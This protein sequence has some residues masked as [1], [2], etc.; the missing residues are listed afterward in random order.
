VKSGGPI[1][2]FFMN[3][4]TDFSR[5]ITAL[6]TALGSGS[7]AVIRISGSESWSIVSKVFKGSD[8]SGVAAN[9]VHFGRIIDERREIDQVLI[10]VFK[11]PHSYTGEDCIEISCHA[12]PFLVGEITN[13]LIKNG[14]D[15]AR[16][17]EFTLRSFLNGKIDLSQAEA[18]SSIVQA[19]SRM[20]V[21]NSLQ[22][23]EGA[24]TKKVHSI[25]E[26]ILALT[27]TL[28][29]DLDFSEEN[30]TI[31]EP[32][33]T[34]KELALIDNELLHLA[35][36]FN[37]ARIFESGI[38][39]AII[40]EPNVGKSTLL[41]AMLGENRAITSDIPGTTRDLIKEN[42]LIDHIFIT[43]T[44]TAG[45]RDSRDEIENEGIRRTQETAERADIVLLVIDISR[46]MTPESQKKLHKT[47]NQFS[48]KL[49]IVANKT[50][51]G[52]DKKTDQILSK[53]GLPVIKGSAI[54]RRGLEQLREN[55]GE[56]V[57]R[58]YEHLGDEIVVT[59]GRQ[60]DAIIQ[61]AESV[62][63]A[64]KSIELQSG[65][66]FTTIDLHN[67]LNALGEISGETVSDDILN[68]IFSNF[69]IGK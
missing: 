9:T 13:L 32:T 39:L 4:L 47:I 55:I 40:G 46:E 53:S 2:A 41:N 26:R 27:A 24:L 54:E 11:A 14:A 17:G 67:A 23:L 8:L 28:E 12:N 6:A 21:Y 62:R 59:S 20:G 68:H 16:P 66:E 65:Y 61:A 31:A 10:T 22:Q 1:G 52:L 38:S 45:L 63:K 19:K 69:C 5:T 56:W 30:L 33:T 35:D 25:K 34:A 48:G 51:R 7:I 15:H 3:K 43:V 50:D 36:S 29:I 64:G 18:V 37:L 42:I 44:D 58:R 49:I 57:R 60:R